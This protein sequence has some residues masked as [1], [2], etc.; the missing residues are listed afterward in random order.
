MRPEAGWDYAGW[1]AD[2][3]VS[4]HQHVYEELKVGGLPY[5]VAGVG[6]GG[7]PRPCPA[8]RVDG[9][10]VCVEGTGALL[11]TATDRTLTLDYRKPD[12]AM[13]TSLR[14]LEISRDS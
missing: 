2:L 12:S 3:V 7:L 5:V 9:S 6:T 10:V 1:G 8:E 11:V 13:G 4:G 14:T